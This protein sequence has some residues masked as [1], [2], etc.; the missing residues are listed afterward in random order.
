MV[1]SSICGSCAAHSGWMFGVAPSCGE[2]RDVVGV[3]HLQV[4][5]VMPAA[6]APL[7]ARAAATASSASPDRAVAEG[8]EVHL[9]ALAVQRGHERAQQLPGR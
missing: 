5:Q 2:A 8:V 7:R 9:E 6:L 3:D 1:R 4:G